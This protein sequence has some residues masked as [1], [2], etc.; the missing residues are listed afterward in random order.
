MAH[1]FTSRFRARLRANIR[2][3]VRAVW[4]VLLCL[5]GSPPASAQPLDQA[6]TAC[7]SGSV[8][9]L[10]QSWTEAQ[11]SWWY[12]T[13]QGSRLLPLAWALALKTP[14]GQD[15]F[16]GTRNLTG[17]GYLANPASRDNP[18]GLP[19]GF[20]VDHQPSRS[21]DLM[22]DR[23]PETC[24]A[25]TMRAPW[26][27]LNC[28]ACHTAELAFGGT[29]LRVDGAPTVADF[30]GLV[31]G[32]EAALRST[33][34]D[35]DRF[36]RFALDVTGGSSDPGDIASLV[37]QIEE[38]LA[39]MAA[40][41][42]AN[43][44]SADGGAEGANPVQANPVQAGP[45]RLDAQG[46]ILTKVALI[47]GG[48]DQPRDH[49]SDAPA[50]YPFIW[51]THQQGKLQWNGIADNI[52]TPRLLGRETDIGAL[53]RNTSEVIGVFAQIEADRGWAALG[54]DSSVRV[55]EM[56]GLERLLSRL[57]SPRWPEA[58][59]GPIDRSLASDG[60]ALFAAR[61]AGC[62]GF[63]APGDLTTPAGEKMVPLPEAG[64]DVFLACN[65]FLRQANAGNMTGQKT[66]GVKG[67]PIAAQDAAHKMLVNAAVGAVLGRLDDLLPAL[68][69]DVAPLGDGQLRAAL[70]PDLEY[71]PGVAD[72][73][74]KA[75]ARTCLTTRHPLLAYKARPLNG[76]WATAPYLHN[77]SVPS[78]YDLLLPARIANVAPLD[79]GLAAPAGPVRPE[80]FTIGSRAFDP[81]DVG[82]AKGGAAAGWTFRV[83]DASGGVI[84]GNSNAGHDYGNAEF[85]EA[86]RRAIVEYL[87][88][89]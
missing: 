61:C 85:T 68:F 84:P 70:G 21:A 28:A 2:A 83:R 6:R 23:F 18:Y 82:L 38:Q 1:F 26:V 17:L 41:R 81:S 65:T 76:I 19:V 69:D 73:K 42:K 87:K 11:R 75:E 44:G 35:P 88:T 52:L 77:G 13:T 24:R 46:H 27:G 39:W 64:T 53:V 50:S 36:R 86:E 74:K 7:S 60:Q 67:D 34:D 56:I 16:F 79:G 33:L 51:N 31:D 45:G 30:A 58:V 63:L 54:Y 8:I 22:C 80:T 4:L 10:D 71:L 72:P 66:F 32:T 14:D 37:G 49:V 78:L 47:N 15:A 55:R 3:N 20:A 89:L 59:F 62:H 12:T 29:R 9:C 43:D 57:S 40:L 5:A 25:R 48:G